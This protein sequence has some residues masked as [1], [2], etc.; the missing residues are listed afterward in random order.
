MRLFVA[1]K[2]LAGKVAGAGAGDEHDR[3]SLVCAGAS[4]L[5][6]PGPRRGGF[7]SSKVPCMSYLNIARCLPITVRLFVVQKKLAGKV[8][9]GAGDAQ[10][11]H[12]SGQCAGASALARPSAWWVPTTSPPASNQVS[13]VYIISI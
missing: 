4:A 2:K 6:P 13:F 3:P 11:T 8:A 10:Q 9:G 7:L 1:Q 12:Q 5:A